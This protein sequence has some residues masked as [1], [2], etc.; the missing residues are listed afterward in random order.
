M[1]TRCGTFAIVGKPNVGKSTLLNALVG[2][3]LAIVSRKPQATRE[4]VI[5]VRTEPD[6]Q[7]V[8]VDLPGLLDPEYLMHEAMREAAVVWVRKADAVLHLHHAST[9]PLPSLTSLAPEIGPTGPIATVITKVDLRKPGPVADTHAEGVVFGVSARSN[10]G[11]DALLG[12]CRLQAPHGPFRHD[13]D[14]V[15]T[16]PM[17]FFVTEFVREA[18]FDLLSDE[19]PYSL[20]AEVDEYRESSKPVYI[21]VTVFVERETQKRMVIGKGGRTVKA[22]GRQAREKIEALVGEKVYLDLWIKTLPKWRS[23]PTQ[24]A[25]FGLVTSHGRNA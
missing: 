8:F 24:L 17:R 25:R 5:G 13:A 1:T 23:D 7:F 15:S 22:L 14:D 9:T 4:P 10:S 3:K 12:W 20:V 6:I 2:E 11:I 18:A 21:R 16:Q 19:L